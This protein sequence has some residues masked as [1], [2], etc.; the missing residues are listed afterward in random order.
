MGTHRCNIAKILIQR[1]A[2]A[3]LVNKYGW[4]PIHTA[5]FSGM[6]SGQGHRIIRCIWEN[7]GDVEKVSMTASQETTKR[8]CMQVPA[9]SG[10]TCVL[11]KLNVFNVRVSIDKESDAELAKMY[12]EILAN[13]Y[14]LKLD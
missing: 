6:G 5:E 8:R 7:M 3:Y 12:K 10:N 2:K 11:P 9:K 14:G 4:N 13:K 1:G